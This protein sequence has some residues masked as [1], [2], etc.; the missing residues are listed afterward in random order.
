MH[1]FKSD[2]YGHHLKTLVLGYIRPELNYTSRGVPCVVSLLCTPGLLKLARGTYRRH[3]DGQESGYELSFSASIRK[4]CGRPILFL[5][6][7]YTFRSFTAC[8]FKISP[9]AMIYASKY[10]ILMPLTCKLVATST[11]GTMRMIE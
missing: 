11:S 2:F 1:P 4:I 6:E 8:L 5:V 3:R 9:E 7:V 10:R